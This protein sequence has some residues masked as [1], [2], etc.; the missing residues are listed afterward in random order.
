MASEWL[1]ERWRPVAVSTLAVGTPIGGAVVG[2]LGPDI[3]ER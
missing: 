1:P 3:A 2:S